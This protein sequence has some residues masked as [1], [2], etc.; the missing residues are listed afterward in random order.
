MPAENGVGPW[1]A[2]AIVRGWLTWLSA[3]FFSEASWRHQDRGYARGS[4][5]RATC[6]LKFLCAMLR[7]ASRADRAWL[8]FICCALAWFF[9]GLCRIGGGASYGRGKHEQGR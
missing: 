9:W 1:W 7:D 3:L 2:P 6:D 5:D 8:A 4:P